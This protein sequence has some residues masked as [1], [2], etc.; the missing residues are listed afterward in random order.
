MFVLESGKLDQLAYS[1]PV[2]TNSSKFKALLLLV[3]A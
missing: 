1:I 2:R 3:V